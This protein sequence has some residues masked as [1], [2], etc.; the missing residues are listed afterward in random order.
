MVHLSPFRNHV[1][2][3]SSLSTSRVTTYMLG[4]RDKYRVQPTVRTRAHHACVG[5]VFIS[6]Q[7]RPGKC[8][9][10]LA[11]LPSSELTRQLMKSLVLQKVCTS[12]SSHSVSPSPFPLFSDEQFERLYTLE[13]TDQALFWRRCRYQMAISESSLA[14]N[15]TFFAS[16][17][18]KHADIV[19]LIGL[20]HTHVMRY[21]DMPAL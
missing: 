18:R 12:F 15:S 2:V 10:R 17:L 11:T 19:D 5:K 6:G 7:S 21:R 3:D 1:I 9:S 4:Q 8:Q 13:I 16:L 14:H 20:L